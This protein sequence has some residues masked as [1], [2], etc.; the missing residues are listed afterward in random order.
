MVHTHSDHSQMEEQ[1]RAWGRPGRETNSPR[2]DRRASSF[3]P[4]LR[5]CVRLSAALALAFCACGNGCQAKGNKVPFESIS[6]SA[7]GRNLRSLWSFH[8]GAGAALEGGGV[9]FSYT[10]RLPEDDFGKLAVEVGFRWD[11]YRHLWIRPP[12]AEESFRVDLEAAPESLTRALK[13]SG[14]ALPGGS[15]SAAEFALRSMRYFF[16]LPL[17]AAVGR[18]EFRNVVS[19]PDLTAPTVVELA[20]VTPSAPVGSCF[21]YRDTQTGLLSKVIYELPYG[22]GGLRVVRFSRYATIQGIKVAEERTH[23]VFSGP[24]GRKAQDPFFP[25]TPESEAESAFLF[26]EQ[27]SHVVLLNREEARLA[28]PLPEEEKPR[29]SP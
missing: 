26:K 5:P 21:L 6:D 22:S 14:L 12:Q 7:V 27:V 28:F 29:G 20:P 10:L 11:D 19:P 17:A 15:P 2:D 4:V 1:N 24:E 8:G 18:W 16:A 9:R 3:H 23:A 13:E 25:S